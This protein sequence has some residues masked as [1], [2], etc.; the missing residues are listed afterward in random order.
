MNSIYKSFSPKV[1]NYIIRH[2]NSKEDAED[3]L[4]DTF[5]I[6][7]HKGKSKEDTPLLFTIAQGKI[8]DG[9]LPPFKLG[10]TYFVEV[11]PNIIVSHMLAQEL[12]GTRPLFYNA[13]S[14]CVDT[15]GQLEQDQQ[16]TIHAPLFGAGLAGGSWEFIHELLKDSW[17]RQR[18][19]PVTFFYLEN[20]KPVGFEEFLK[21]LPE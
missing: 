14:R 15:V 9:S 12:G 17:M 5:L 1:F 19:I 11:T 10:S 21:N 20:A 7:F 3:I 2:V 13:L 16:A 6:F 18:D 4:Q 8:V